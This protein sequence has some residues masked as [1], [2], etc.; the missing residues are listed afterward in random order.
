MNI[1]WELAHSLTVDDGQ[2]IRCVG[3]LP[4]T[5]DG[6]DA[7]RLVVGTQGGAL[8]QW[9]LPSQS[10]TP[11][12][13]QHDNGVTALVVADQNTYVTGCK[14]SKIRVF[15]AT[16]HELI[17]T[18]Q[19]HEK[20]VTS[21]SW[22]N[23]KYLLSGSWD[24]T[25]KIWDIHKGVMLATL[26]NHENSTCVCGLVGAS[27]DDVFVATGSAGIA[28]NSQISNHSVRIWKITIATGQVQLLHTV[29]NDHQGPI[30]DICLNTETG[31]LATCSNDGTV[32][33]RTTDSGECIET[34]SFPPVQEVP[35]LLSVGSCAS[36]MMAAAEDGHVVFWNNTETPQLIRHP[37][38]VWTIRS[39]SDGDVVTCCQDGVLRIFTQSAD[40]VAPEDVR[41]AFDAAVQATLT[42]RGPTNEEV[43]KLPKWELNALQQGKSE[44][45]IQLFQKDG[46]AIAAQWSA[47]SGTWIE[48]GQVVG[49]P[50]QEEGGAGAVDGVQYDHV[51]PIEVDQTGGG[52]AKLQIGYNTGENTF[53]AAQRFID[54]HM[55]PQHHLSEIADYITQR[56]GAAA[57]TIGAGPVSAGPAAGA[58]VPLAHYEY[59][60]VKAFK[61][62][63]LG[64]ATNFEK[65]LDKIRQVGTLSDADLATL[66]ELTD[67]LAATN[68]YHASK[69]D[70]AGCK[71]ILAML[72]NWEPAQAFP[73]LDLARLA[74][75]HPDSSKW[76]WKTILT[77]ACA[78]CEK[79]VSGVAVPMLTMRLIANSFKST[80]SAALDLTRVLSLTDKTV[81]SR[82]KN[83][84]LSAV[85]VVL[86]ISVNHSNDN[87]V[88]TEVVTQVNTILQNFSTHDAETMTRAL[89]A[90]GTVCVQ[91][92]TAKKVA[93]SFFLQTKVEMAASPHGDKAKGVAKEL[94]SVLQ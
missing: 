85:T 83:V 24:G 21:L 40:R 69:L 1:D 7:Y 6:G 63:E 78:L 33:V 9:S 66:K 88:A 73:A 41:Q 43:A 2:G 79:D 51:L 76:D 82:N 52:V 44:G 4:A 93:Q 80:A 53:T 5:E 90:L 92:A 3:E 65:L 18:L 38:S 11:I 23:G 34:L 48:V 35:M 32:K 49:G 61:T 31:L 70:P 13:Y 20:P 74:I 72:T 47:T 46:I 94:Y 87:A 64:K 29:A 60:P 25:A 84:R 62:F 86:N 16:T 89:L 8:Y 17:R 14:D 30:R 27:E 58:G 45:Q 77:A 55:L 19:G 56:L 57:P 10:L 59:L 42:K 26:P 36:G 39:L 54:S 71:I 81:A 50:N 28:Q 68:R 67:V 75:L 37:S 22:A 12:G 15:D 91:N